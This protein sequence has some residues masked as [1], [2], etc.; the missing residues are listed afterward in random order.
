MMNEKNKLTITEIAE[1]IHYNPFSKPNQ[2][3]LEVGKIIHEALGYDGDKVFERYIK[4]KFKNKKSNEIKEEIWKIVGKPD[5]I[6]NNKIIEFKTLE[7][8]FQYF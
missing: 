8:F 6:E 2:E 5:R 3:V 7:S 1:L 4:I